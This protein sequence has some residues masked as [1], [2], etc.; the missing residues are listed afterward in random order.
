[1]TSVIVGVN[2]NVKSGALKECHI[3]IFKT[4]DT[5][6]SLCSRNTHLLP[7]KPNFFSSSRTR[8]QGFS[9]E[10]YFSPADKAAKYVV[11]T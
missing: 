8:Y 2:E 5:C 7:T 10:L 4:I 11:V 6:I 9:Y 1:M 3:N